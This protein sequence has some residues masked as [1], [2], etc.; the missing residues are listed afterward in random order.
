MAWKLDDKQS[1]EISNR[2]IFHVLSLKKVKI[3]CRGLAIGILASNGHILVSMN[4]YRQLWE[5]AF[6][7]YRLR[8]SFQCQWIPGSEQSAL[9]STRSKLRTQPIEYRT[10]TQ[11]R[12]RW[13]DEEC[14][15]TMDSATLKKKTR[16]ASKRMY[17]HSREFDLNR[18]V[19]YTAHKRH[20]G[21]KSWRKFK[22]MIIP[23][24]W[25]SKTAL[26]ER[27]I[28]QLGLKEPTLPLGNTWLVKMRRSYCFLRLWLHF[29]WQS[30][31]RKLPWHW[32]KCIQGIVSCLISTE[33]LTSSI[34]GKCLVSSLIATNSCETEVHDTTSEDPAEWKWLVTQSWKSP[35]RRMHAK[36]WH[37]GE[38]SLIDLPNVN[39]SSWSTHVMRFVLVAKN[40]FC[41]A[42]LQ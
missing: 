16:R 40:R 17:R 24:N 36:I 13:F 25:H 14:F 5:T 7:L 10:S 26:K 38:G 19:K 11:R 30:W 32:D 28:S 20:S 2:Q 6:N 35:G 34:L 4:A 22:K 12:N 42:F 15:G 18:I 1:T 21:E 39:L 37:E 29:I 3:F 41:H 27:E 8:K 9:T 23:S 31:T 33:L